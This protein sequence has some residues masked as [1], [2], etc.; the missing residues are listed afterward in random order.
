M[1]APK[2]LEELEAEIQELQAQ[3]RELSSADGS[4]APRERDRREEYLDIAGVMLLGL[5]TQGR[6]TYANTRTAEAVGLTRQDILGQRWIDRFLPERVRADVNDTFAQVIRGETADEGHYVGRIVQQDGAERAIRWYTRVVRDETGAIVGIHA[7]GED[8]TDQLKA[9][10]DLAASEAKFRAIFED[11]NVA[12]GLATPHGRIT[13]TNRAMEEM[14]GY[15]AD[16]LK[17]MQVI[18]CIHPDDRERVDKLYRG[19][20][21]GRSSGTRDDT[22]YLRKDG[23]AVWGSRA[24]ATVRTPDGRLL[25]L[26]AIIVD[27]T[28]RRRDEQE[29]REHRSRLQLINEIATGVRSGMTVDQIVEATVDRLAAEFP[30]IRV[31]YGAV[32]DDGDLTMLCSRQPEAMPSIAGLSV[33]LSTADDYLAALRNDRAVIVSDIS[34]DARLAPLAGVIGEGGAR[35]MLDVP[36]HDAKGLMGILCLDAPDVRVWSSH[37]I[38][39][40]VDAADYLAIAFRDAATQRQLAGQRLLIDSFDRLGHVLLSTL[41][42]DEILDTLANEVLHAGVFRSLMVA[43]VDDDGGYAEVVRGLFQRAPDNTIITPEGVVGRRYELDGDGILAEVARTGRMVVTEGWDARFD[44][45]LGSPQTYPPTKVAYFI[46]VLA[47]ERVL[48]V[49]ATASELD[50]KQATLRNVEAMGSLLGQVA[51]ALEHAR[52]YQ[53]LRSQEEALRRI[54]TGARCILW[55][56]DVVWAPDANGAPDR[57]WW[58]IEPFDEPSAREFIALDPAEDETYWQAFNRSTPLEHRERMAATAHDALLGGST[59]YTQEYPCVDRNDVTK[60]LL[61]DVFVEPRGKHRWHVVGVCT[62]ITDR[63]R[64]EEEV[65]DRHTELERLVDARTADLTAV[66]SELQEELSRRQEAEDALHATESDRRRL[67]ERLLTVQEAERSHIAREL[68]DQAGQALSSVLVGLRSLRGMSD[69]TQ[70]ERHIDALRVT[71]GRVLD[72]VRTLSFSLR[73]P[74]LD[75]FG[76]VAALERDVEA[77]G[78][79]HDVRLDFVADETVPTDLPEDIEVAVYRVVHAALTN[80]QQHANAKNVSV[81]FRTRDEALHVIVEDDGVGF[82]VDAVLAGPVEGRFGLL[83]MQERL[84]AVGGAVEFESSPDGGSTVFI[85]T[86]TS[87]TPVWPT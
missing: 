33:G 81:V 44:A 18:D 76:L 4:R 37:E 35:A 48:A 60:W 21:A 32:D 63:K 86:P 40:L 62:D 61:E 17:T 22:K 66:N 78:R 36:V 13:D 72:E 74:S 84:H 25:G 11:A 68:H 41:D 7:S 64:R 73:P 85:Q 23:T 43:L 50:E 16:E 55:H 71:T 34:K 69:P 26:A 24:G 27:V 2:S 30:G 1:T 8:I 15:T 29:L 70:V 67:V 39:T 57:L 3:V 49:L 42:R 65:R 59:R 14:L 6:V 20:A 19:A 45:E 31:V 87:R 9:A 82:D 46:P 51:V 75:E 28:Q 77:F 58:D 79:Q 12:M 56:A 47:G 52:A 80:T 53:E 38:A 10:D 54:I 83:A 5:D